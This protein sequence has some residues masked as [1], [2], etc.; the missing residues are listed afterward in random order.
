MTGCAYH[1]GPLV[2]PDPTCRHENFLGSLEGNRVA[3]WLGL[4]G[5]ANLQDAASIPHVL[6]TQWLWEKIIWPR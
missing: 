2:E 1:L 3:I 5:Y 6:A 4:E